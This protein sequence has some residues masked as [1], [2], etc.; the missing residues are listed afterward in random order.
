MNS[1]L[2][3]WADDVAEEQWYVDVSFD[4]TLQTTISP[5]R[6]NSIAAIVIDMES[7]R[8]LYEKNAR[9][10]MPMA[11]TTK[12]MT[13]IVAIE[14]GNL[15]DEV[16]I[17]KRA[18][19]VWGS[20]IHLQVGEKLKL[21][22]LLYGLMLRSGNDA[23]IAIAEHIGGSVE[24][25]CQIM[26]DKAKELGLPNSHFT[27]PHG[28][29]MPGHYTTAYE[30]ACL[31]S[32]ALK[33]PIFN[34]IVG[35]KQTS[36]GNRQLYNTNEL[37]GAY[38]GVDGVKTGYTGQAGRCLV[39]SATK[40]DMRIITVVLGC[41]TRTARAQSSTNL[42]N[43]AFSNFKEEILARQGDVV[44]KLTV[45]KGIKNEAAVAIK[46][47]IILPL[48]KDELKAVEKIVSYKK[49]LHAPVARNVEVGNIKWV[50]NGNTVAEGKLVTSEAVRKKTVGDVIRQFFEEI[51]KKF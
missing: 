40:N 49:S 8:V 41:P 1:G 18:A 45:E 37:L 17:S 36:I 50:I 28:L 12:I 48:N 20:E 30:L 5:P 9:R 15:E 14:K 21:R 7:G 46:E 31:T 2:V 32:Y 19:T 44:G 23:A 43:Y 47:N 29:D 27:S 4:R 24:E 6:L 33:N 3:V 38:P 26:N 35:T 10:S 25:F 16:T 22:D 39:T 42:L 13:A 34:E 51:R 11:S